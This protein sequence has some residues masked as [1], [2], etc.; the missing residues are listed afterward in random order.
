[1]KE[2]IQEKRGLPKT[3]SGTPGKWEKGKGTNNSFQGQCKKE[4]SNRPLIDLLM[5]KKRLPEEPKP[6]KEFIRAESL[7]N[8]KHLS[9]QG[10]KGDPQIKQN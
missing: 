6:F 10:G 5:L 9:P 2:R 7:T 1:M 8:P 3:T 4:M